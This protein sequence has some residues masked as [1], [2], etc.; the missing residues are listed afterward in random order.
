M[1]GVK[2][3]GV[4]TVKMAAAKMADRLIEIETQY[5]QRGVAKCVT[6]N[7]TLS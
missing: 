3:A 2:M 1:A 6:Q 5:Q 4:Q 7:A